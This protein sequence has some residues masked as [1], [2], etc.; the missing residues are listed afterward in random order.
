MARN[1]VSVIQFCQICAFF[2]AQLANG[3][4]INQIMT[5]TEKMG[6]YKW[7][8]LV[9]AMSSSI[10]GCIDILTQ[11]LMHVK[12]S[13]YVVFV[14]SFL[15]DFPVFGQIF[16]CVF[17]SAFALVISLLSAQFA[18][19]YF[20][21]CQQTIL[22]HLEGHKIIYIFIPCIICTFVWFQLAYWFACC[23]PEKQELLREDLETQYGED[24]STIPFSAI[25]F[26]RKNQSTGEIEWMGSDLVAAG[27][28]AVIVWGCFSV[29]S[30]CGWKTFTV[31]RDNHS[32]LLSPKTI[33]SN[34][35]VFKTLV[36]QSVLPLILVFAPSGIVLA[37]PLFGLYEGPLVN[38]VGI[39]VAFYPTLEPVITLLFV[40]EFK[41]FRCCR[42][43][44][45]VFE[46]VPRN[47]MIT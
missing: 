5:K 45:R 15:K 33:G 41:K 7:L 28:C 40:K 9:F 36:A 26:W 18:F 39:S 37:L 1:Y 20:V 31:L 24:S 8:M 34:K 12:G 2:F 25:M 6:G 44:D 22:K 27:G 16:V 4:L 21:L 3:Y 11:P 47:S 46:V 35:K 42:K 19:R 14:T 23:T 32:S 30:F 38:I 10:Y 29:M 43:K 17:C 13:I